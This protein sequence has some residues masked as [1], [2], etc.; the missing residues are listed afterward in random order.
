MK[1]KFSV[2]K[3]IGLV[4]V[5]FSLAGSQENVLSEKEKRTL[6]KTY[7]ETA[8]RHFQAQ[9]YGKAI[10]YYEQILKLDPEQVQP[11]K[12]IEICRRKIREKYESALKEVDQMVSDG[13]YNSAYFKIREVIEMDPTNPEL[14]RYQKQ[15]GSIKEIFGEI[16]GKTKKD[17]LLRRSIAEYLKNPGGNVRF[18]INSAIYVSQLPPDDARLERYLDLLEKE[19]TKEYKSIEIVPGMTLVEQKLVA[20]LNYIYDGKYDR[21]IIECNDVLELE[22]ENVLALKRLGSSYYALNKVKEAKEVWKRALKID[23]KDEE[24]KM[25]LKQ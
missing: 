2:F 17:N 6:I 19:F 10:N 20:A 18:A 4:A 16:T 21:A 14:K 12:L 3:I 24:I 11:P 13:K 22:P 7:Y 8:I 25:F 23:P 5:I 15:L 9:E 1:L